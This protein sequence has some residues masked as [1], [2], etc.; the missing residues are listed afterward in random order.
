[1]NTRKTLPMNGALL[2]HGGK[3]AN[4]APASPVS[5]I[6][7]GAGDFPI[8]DAIMDESEFIWNEDA[9]PV[10]NYELLGQRL[11]ASGDLYRRPGY[12]AGL[13][14]GSTRPNIDPEIIAKS[15]RLAA[16]IADRVRVRFIKAGNTRGNHIPSFHLSTMLASEAFLQQFRPVDNVVKVPAY[17]PDFTLLRPG[18]NDGG[19]GHRFLYVGPDAQVEHSLEATSAFLD[20]MAFAGNA[21]KTN[22]VAAALTVMMRDHW[23][24]ARPIIIATSA[25]SHGGKDTILHFATGAT[26][27]LSISYEPTDWALQK[28]FVAAVKHAPETGV[29]IVENARLGRSDKQIASAFLERFIHDTEPL[30]YAPG[31]GEPVKRKN[32]IVLGISTNFGQVSEDLMNR[33]L[34]IHLAPVGDVGNRESHIGNPKWEYLPANRARIEAEMRGL[35]ETW[36]KAGCPLDLSVKHPMSSWAATVGGILKVGGFTDFLGNYGL[37]RTADDAVRKGLG[38]LG[39]DHPDQWLRPDDWARHAV[40]LG[41]VK[42]ILPVN[43]R[44]T[45]KSRERGIG[46]V[47]SAHR[48]E[49]FHVVTDDARVSLKLEKARRRFAGSEPST[50]Y[51]FSTLQKEAVPEDPAPAC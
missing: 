45:D 33:G 34:P 7:P 13:L 23:P 30:L 36:K 27:R 24:G 4:G 5:P 14:L 12:G 16:I 21:D 19:P 35:I 3:E 41:L 38:L 11:S 37:R 15:G 17:L 8:P 31:T 1:M 10:C 25:K 42:T 51:R 6:M 48:D 39:A 40:V 46:T 43:D 32:D 28:A 2:R 44:D 22:A 29:V 26:P 47:L 50:R 9:S 49:I 20:V 18:Y